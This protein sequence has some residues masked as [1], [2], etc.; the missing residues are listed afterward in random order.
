MEEQSEEKP[1]LYTEDRQSQ[2]SYHFRH[3]THS[4]GAS[5]HGSAATRARAKAEAAKVK[6]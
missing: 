6:A 3:S 5:S 1:L 4:S 2:Y